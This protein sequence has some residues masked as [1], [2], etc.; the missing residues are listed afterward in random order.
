MII[1]FLQLDITCAKTNF[2]ITKWGRG[3][4]NWGKDYKSSK[5]IKSRCRL[6][7]T[8]EGLPIGVGHTVSLTVMTISNA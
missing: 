4:T 5:K 2:G 3:I 8:G 6:S 7:T 1:K